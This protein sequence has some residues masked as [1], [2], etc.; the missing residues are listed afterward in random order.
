M[1]ARMAT[2]PATR[3]RSTAKARVRVLPDTLSENRFP[4]RDPMMAAAVTAEV[5]P[6]NPA[7]WGKTPRNAPC[8]CGSGKKYKKCHGA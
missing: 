4:I 1:P 3:T 5:D 6:R 8:P 2:Y 7:T